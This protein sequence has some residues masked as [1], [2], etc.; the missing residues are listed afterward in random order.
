MKKK[1]KETYG[2]FKANIKMPVISRLQDGK[3]QDIIN[4]RFKRNLK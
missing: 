2:Y 3:I 4:N 1:I